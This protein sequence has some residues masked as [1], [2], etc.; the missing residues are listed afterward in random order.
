MGKRSGRTGGH[1]GRGKGAGK[2]A[3]ASKQIARLETVFGREDDSVIHALKVDAARAVGRVVGTFDCGDGTHLLPYPCALEGID[4]DIVGIPVR[5]SWTEDMHVDALNA[6]EAKYFTAWLEETYHKYPLQELNYFEHNLEVWRQVWRTAFERADI[7]AIIL[8]ARIPL[9]H[10]SEAMFQHIR[11]KLEKDVVLVLNKADLVPPA[12]IELWREHFSRRFPGL[13]VVPFSVPKSGSGRVEQLPCVDEFLDALKACTL[14]RG[15]ARIPAAPFFEGVREDNPT[16]PVERIPEEFITVVLQGDPNM[17]KSSVINAVFGRKLVSSSATPGHTKHFQTLFLSRGV[18]F[19][20]SP[21]VVCPKLGVPK[22]LQVIFGSYRIAQV[23][24]PYHV[25][26]FIA[27]RCRP[28]LPE[29]LKLA[30]FRDKDAE[31]DEPWCPLSLCEAYARKRG[32]FRRGGRPDPHRAANRLLQDALNGI[33]A[34]CLC[35]APPG[36]DAAAV[37][38]AAAAA[39]PRP[40]WMAYRTAS[41]D[42]GDAHSGS[43]SAGEEPRGHSSDED[44]VPADA[45]AEAPV[46]AAAPST[47]ASRVRNAFALLGGDDS[48]SENSDA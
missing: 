20:D 46:P 24:E 35:F 33:G 42:E 25:V 48:Q 21:G 19:C 36:V 39:P 47:A 26:R 45:A 12:A 13:R 2:G 3:D 43:A 22:P 38:A 34:M 18:C 37:R 41:D 14:A 31:P 15:S 17:G 7:V 32:F 8:D 4:K 23:R 11:L 29:L 40:A 30:A 6:Q 10:F 16:A 1:G 9:F 44:P 27:E 5:P 28:P